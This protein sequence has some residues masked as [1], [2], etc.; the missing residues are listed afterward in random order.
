MATMTF[1]LPAGLSPELGRELERSSLAGGPDSMPCTTAFRF[2]DDQLKL[3]SPAE[4]SAY[5]VAPWTVDELGT[6]MGTSATLME[7]TAPYRLLVEIARGKVNQVRNQAANWAAG[8][9]HIPDALRDAIHQA[10][11]TFGHA[12]CA[13]DHRETDALARQALAAAYQVADGLVKTYVDQVF[14]LRHQQSPRFDTALSVPLHPG[15]PTG[16]VRGQ[17]TRTF[18]RVS[19]PLSW[20]L[21]E[22][23]ETVY[24][25]DAF[26]QLLNW[27]EANELDVTAGPLI[28]FSSSQL[29]AWLWLWERDLPSMA[30]FMCRFVEA[31]VRRYRSRIR[32]W[33]LTAASNWASVLG[34]GED[35]LLGLTF[36][37]GEAA[38]QVDPGV[39][40]VLGISQPWGE[41]LVRSDRNSPFIFAD[42][43]IR[44]GLNL[45]AIN[46][47]VV[48]GV[49]GRGSY[50]RDPLD[51][52]R[53]LDLYTLLGVPLQVT[54]G[55]PASDA[56][57]PD[58]DPELTP[59]FG[60]RT[61]GFT[62]ATQAAWAAQFAA[63]ALC[64]PSVQAIHWTHFSDAVPHLFPHCG[65]L[66]RD[67]QARPVL[68]TLRRLRETHLR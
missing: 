27:A 10:T 18:T 20:H 6:V 38:R 25:W 39:E 55:Y 48:M 3:M 31:A 11:F 57:D 4:D 40:L 54:L 8:G 29:P 66:D 67:G 32:R 7:R 35:E 34:L 52:V 49:Q 53:L 30:T 12:V 26:D 59:G 62:A 64:K 63:L 51:T 14:A 68:Q 15:L 60:S 24:R 1:Q 2:R 22:G 45:S 5:L 17:I 58:A 43:L 21:V 61:G 28:D 65:L 9:L 19:L 42:N 41:Y 46:L 33:Q 16:D 56:S 47:E 36:R 37:L 50:C 44:S 23:A 13:G